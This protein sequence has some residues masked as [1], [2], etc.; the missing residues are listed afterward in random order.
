MVLF[1]FVSDLWK[2]A[3]RTNGLGPVCMAHEE[4]NVGNDFWEEMDGIANQLK[5]MVRRWGLQHKK[6]Y[7]GKNWDVSR[8]W[9]L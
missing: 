4:M 9:V 1:R 8:R 5:A 2:L 3:R 6:I 7:Y